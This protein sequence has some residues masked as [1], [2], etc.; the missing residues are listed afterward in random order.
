MHRAPSAAVLVAL[1]AAPRRRR[2]AALVTAHLTGD[3]TGHARVDL[4]DHD[5]GTQVRLTSV[6]SPSNRA[7][8]I[9][10]AV[11]R[12]VV[13]QIRLGARHGRSSVRPAGHRPVLI[14][15]P[16][17]GRQLGDQ[18]LRS[19]ATGSVGVMVARNFRGRSSS[20]VCRSLLVR[21]RWPGR[22]GG[23]RG[24]RAGSTSRGGAS[25]TAAAT[26]RGRPVARPASHD[27]GRSHG[28]RPGVVGVVLVRPSAAQQPG[29]AAKV[30]GTSTTIW[31]AATSC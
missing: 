9:L 28:H 17:F 7:F 1:H 8:A 31:S 3:I 27:A 14:P 24:G 29:S 6:L 26:R 5:E 2:A 25:P 21:A 22:A 15:A 20:A 13:R 11:A 16:S 10:A 19:W 30:A 12:P 4:A 18:S 23:R